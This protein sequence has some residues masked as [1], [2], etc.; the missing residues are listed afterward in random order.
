MTINGKDRHNLKSGPADENLIGDVKLSTI[1][2]TLDDMQIEKLSEQP[3]Q[4]NTCDTLQNVAGDW[5]SEDLII[6]AEEDAA[7]GFF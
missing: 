5:G 4:R 3:D 1:H 2:I 6:P 7:S